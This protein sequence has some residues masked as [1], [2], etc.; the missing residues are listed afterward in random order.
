[1]RKARTTLG[2]RLAA[3]SVAVELLAAGCATS[4]APSR[5]GTALRVVAVES[6]WGSVAAQ[7]GGDKVEVTDLI[8]NPATDPHAYEPTTVD[9]RAVAMAQV[10][11]VNG[12]GYDAWASKLLAANPASGRQVVNLGDVVGAKA[13]DNPHLWYSPADVR[14]AI[15]AIKAALT[16]ADPV[17]S[18]FFAAQQEKLESVG[19]KAYNELISGIKARHGGTPVGASE[20][21]FAM[22]TPALGLDLVTPPGFLRAVTEGT[23]PTVRD[24][25]VIDDQIASHKIAVYLYNTQNTT[26]DV[27]AQVDAAKAAGIPVVPMTETLV[28]EGATFQDWQC[29]QL[30]ALDS[31]LASATTASATAMATT[32]A[33]T[34]A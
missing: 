1:M 7:L 9:A 13:G 5:A 4:T 23:E 12:V 33:R 6:V 20:S 10:V 25:R 31:A 15:D 22:L 27:K 14:A 30:G 28:P 16:K 2:W 8:S 24:K 3:A 18:A 19:L 34:M 17:D 21:I 32:A 29:A 11:V 26:P